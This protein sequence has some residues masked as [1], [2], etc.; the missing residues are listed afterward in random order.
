MCCFT[1]QTKR[2]T[3]QCT[4]A[5]R[6]VCWSTNIFVV[7]TETLE[8]RLLVTVVL[9]DWSFCDFK[10]VLQGP[11]IQPCWTLSTTAIFILTESC[12]PGALICIYYSSLSS[13]VIT[14]LKC[15]VQL[16]SQN[17]LAKG[18]YF[19]CIGSK[20]IRPSNMYQ[21]NHLF[22]VTPIISLPNLSSNVT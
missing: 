8:A 21:S 18:V 14:N 6:L 11:H 2:L 9:A 12:C 20:C 22:W 17:A 10:D 4:C 3:G 19:F 16:F 1:S 5:V 7:V 13:V 15:K